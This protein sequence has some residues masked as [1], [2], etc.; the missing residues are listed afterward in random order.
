[1]TPG[2][3]TANT[4]P[5]GGHSGHW[6]LAALLLSALI[7][8]LF[9]IAVATI[10][11]LLIGAWNINEVELHH[12]KFAVLGGRVGIFGL[13]GLSILALVSGVMGLVRATR[14][15]QPFGLP[16]AG[17]A[18]AVVALA[19]SVVLVIAGEYVAEDTHRLRS[20]H[21]RFRPADAAL[22]QEVK[23]AVEQN[24]QLQAFWDQAMKNGVLTELKAEEILRMAGRRAPRPK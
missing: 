19:V 17:T 6:G 13:L 23:L 16:V 10:L 14:R 11:G 1:M 8:I 20:E 22:I 2:S 21:P 5:Q 7:L 3:N 15:R 18:A 12:I 4:D 9:P 24:P